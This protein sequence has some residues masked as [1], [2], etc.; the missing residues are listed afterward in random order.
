KCSPFHAKSNCYLSDLFYTQ[1]FAFEV[2]H[3]DEFH[4]IAQ[5]VYKI[6]N[7]LTSNNIAHNMTIVKGD[8][9][10]SSENVLRI[11]LWFRQ[12]VIN[13]K[14]FDRCNFACFELAGYMTLHSEDV[15]NSLTESELCQHMNDIA[16][17]SEEQKRIKDDVKSLL[18]ELV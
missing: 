2:Q 13:G 6:T 14:N 1:A 11:F 17:S 9:F 8:S 7:Y 16:L 12:S 10:S 18:D 3:V 15:Y 5:Y 4:R